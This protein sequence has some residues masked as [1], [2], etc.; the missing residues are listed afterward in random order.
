MENCQ[1]Q[2]NYGAFSTLQ[3]PVWLYTLPS[4]QL[5]WAN[6]SAQ[7]RLGAQGLEGGNVGSDGTSP[8]AVRLRLKRYGDAVARGQTLGEIWRVK[9]HAQEVPVY[10]LGSGITLE[11]GHRGLLI[12]GHWLPGEPMQRAMLETI[13]DLLVRMGRDGICLEMIAGDEISLWQGLQRGFPSSIYE[14]LPQDLADLRMHHVCLALDTG[15]RQ[16]YR[17]NIEV[18]GQLHHEEVRVVPMGSAEVLVMVR[19][20]TQMVQAQTML[21]EQSQRFQQQ[22]QCDRLLAQV[23]QRISQSLELQVVLDTAVQE[24]RLL[25]QTQRVLVYRFEGADGKGQV[26]AESV[27]EG[28]LPLYHQTLE[29]RCFRVQSQVVEEYGRG[30]IQRT[31]D[32]DTANLSACYRAMLAQIQV[33]ANLVIPIIYGNS[34]WGLLACQQ[35]DAPRAWSD[36]EVETLTQLANQLAIAIQ[37]SELYHQLQ[38]VNQ[39]LQHLATHDKLT[40]LPNRRY[41]DDYLEQEWRR[42]SREQAPLALILCDIDYFKQYNDAYG[43]LGGDGCMV[44]VARA[45]TQAI[46]R[47]ADLTARYG[48]EEFAIILPNTDLAGAV[49]AGQLIQREINQAR[50]PHCKSLIKS[51]ITVSLGIACVQPRLAMPPCHL[52]NLADQALYQAKQQGRDRYCTAT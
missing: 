16:I 23:T 12:E 3:T 30:R 50:I 14:W 52:T 18:A 43:H 19:D 49:R 25:I 45:I 2:V 5:M 8:D 26:I 6:P 41:F 1:H 15:Q 34:L 32:I 11:A 31:A 38:R 48:G 9:V 36:L 27:A 42:L 10:C 13:P 40:G 37:Q 51:H 29:D 35:C 28:W 44:Q 24:L 46:K 21:F 33:R 20:V 17:Q 7:R 4:L 39:E 47:P 22:A